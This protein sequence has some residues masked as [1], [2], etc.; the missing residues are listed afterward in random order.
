MDLRADNK[1]IEGGMI[2]ADWQTHEL[3]ELIQ[4]SRSIRY[5][6]VQPGRF[7]GTGS[8][9][10]R[11]QDYSKGW[12]G[13]DGMHKVS[14]QLESQFKNAKIRPGD[15]VLTVVGAGIGQVVVVPDWL[16][17]A[18]LSR[19]TARIAID[20]EKASPT[21]VRAFLEGPMG[22]R[23]IL[24]CQKQGAQPVVSCRDLARFTVICPTVSEQRAIGTALSDA[25]AMI[26]SLNALIAKKRDFKQAAMQQLLT[27]KTRLPGFKDEWE[28][29]QLG[30]VAKI[31]NEKI[32][33]FGSSAAEFCIELEQIEQNTGRIDRFTDA[34]NRNS[35]KYHFRKGD[36]LFGRLRPYLRKFWL[37]ERD[38]VCS[39]EIWPLIPTPG[40]ITELFLYQ[41]VQ[42]DAFIDAANTAY[43]THMPRADWNVLKRFNFHIPRDPDEQS[44]ISAILSDMDAELVALEAKR[45][46]AKALRQGMMQELLT[47]R[48]RLV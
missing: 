3:G 4:D 27:G 39:T 20:S 48:I 34:R 38:G 25:D 26:D 28:S 47:G 35:S 12:A 23:Q 45:D 17:G 29:E 15:L 37:A 46:K 19:S 36:I 32:N 8:F 42:T 30:D 6:I 2:P 7:E 31:R 16:D 14:F 11:S 5:G 1:R 13:P 44:A 21:Y 43:G 22:N 40:L 9:M 33:T 18:I 24:D 10:L 41:T